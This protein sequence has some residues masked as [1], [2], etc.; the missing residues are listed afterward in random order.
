MNK[1]LKGNIINSFLQD[2]KCS[3]GLFVVNFSRIKVSDVVGFRK[4]L[5][6]K[7]AKIFVMKN[8]LLRRCADQ[9]TSLGVIKEQFSDQIALVAAFQ[10]PFDVA[11]ELDAFI[12]KFESIKFKSGVLNGVAVDSMQFSKVAKIG[13]VKVLQ[14]QLCGMLK[15]PISKL[16]VVLSQ[17]AKKNNE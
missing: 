10:D 7:N 9:V 1:V 12:K 14:S 5:S 2:Y 11:K 17:I 6:G 8:S 4:L 16:L 15:N 13:S 3:V